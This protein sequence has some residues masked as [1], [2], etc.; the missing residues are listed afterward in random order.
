MYERFTNRACVVMRLAEDEARR[1]NHDHVG[2]EHILLGIVKE[3]IRTRKRPG[4]AANVLQQL[5]VLDLRKIR[6]EVEKVVPAGADPA[7]TQQ[8]P[9]TPQAE[10][11]IDH[12]V[13]EAERLKQPEI[14]TGFLLLG[15]MHER[16]SVAARVLRGLGV[17]FE[18][19]REKVLTLLRK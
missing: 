11:V 13:E 12:A 9:K 1:F 14:G 19:L 16:D 5:G 7:R 3:A 18:D 2:P 17:N 6:V 8:Q 15:L 4:V 10:R